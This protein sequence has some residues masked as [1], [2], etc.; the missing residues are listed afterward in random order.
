LG[1]LRQ[2]VAD[3]VAERIEDG[4]TAPATLKARRVGADG[5]AIDVTVMVPREPLGIRAIEVQAGVEGPRNPPPSLRGRINLNWQGVVE[6][7]RA[8]GG[9]IALRAQERARA[10]EEAATQAASATVPATRPAERAEDV[11]L[12]WQTYKVKVEGADKI[13]ATLEMARVDPAAEGVKILDEATFT[14]VVR[15]GD[16]YN[17]PAFLLEAAGAKY[18][19]ADAKEM[20]VRAE[21]RGETLRVE[22]KQEAASALA[23][24]EAP[25]KLVRTAPLTALVQPA[26]PIVGAALPHQVDAVLA[27]QLVSVRDFVPRPGYVLASRG[28]QALPGVAEGGEQG[29]R[30]DLLHFGVAVESYWYTDTCRLVCVQ[31]DLGTPVVSRRVNDPAA[32]T[33]PYERKGR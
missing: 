33:M 10:E 29:W 24:V 27:V 18:T 19:G 5:K 7:L 16:Y 22:M 3:A 32:A 8:E 25:Q 23:P 20:E 21:R 11:W 31:S 15:T 28:K 26:M 1:T 2:R 9:V 12:G 6:A 4:V 30:V 17:L 14:F 13:S